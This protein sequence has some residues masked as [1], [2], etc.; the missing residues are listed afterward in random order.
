[1]KI[2]H[3]FIKHQIFFFFRYEIIFWILKFYLMQYRYIKEFHNIIL[4]FYGAKNYTYNFLLNKISKCKFP[5]ILFEKENVNWKLKIFPK[6]S[7]PIYL[8]CSFVCRMWTVILKHITIFFL[9][10]HQMLSA[11]ALQ[12]FCCFIKIIFNIFLLNF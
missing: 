2:W 6:Q 5:M 3:N 9:S 12:F 1:M 11:E 10:Y 8:F 4:F 7:I